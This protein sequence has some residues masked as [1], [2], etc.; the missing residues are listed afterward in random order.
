MIRTIIIDDEPLQRNQLKTTIEE[1]CPEINL[2]AEFGT[3]R[4]ALQK[5]PHLPFELLLLDI[6]LG[7]M[8]AF[9]LLAQLPV[10]DF[11][12][13]FI[14]AYDDYAIKAFRVNAV[15]YLLK[16][17]DGKELRLAMTKALSRIFSQNERHDL[18]FDYHLAKNRMICISE[19]RSFTF[20]PCEEII[21][22]H[23]NGNY[24]DFIYQDPQGRE[25]ITTASNNILSF[26]Q[27]LSGNAFI[28]IHQS[29][30]VNSKKI[31]KLIK[32]SH[33]AILSNGL[34]IDV[35]RDRWKTVVDTM[36]EQ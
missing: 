2:I 33:K 19:H 4:A 26:E 11:H 31:H 30:L 35:A 15:D 23:A 5:I 14:T 7:D 28:R 29:Y 18:A 8:T 13:I 25:Q 20:I 12:I 22:C 3:G 27:R 36:T 34:E 24:T 1:C 17:V 21:Y 10:N 6:E 9:D 16:P 32:H